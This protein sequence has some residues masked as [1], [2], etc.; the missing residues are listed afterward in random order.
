MKKNFTKLLKWL[1]ALLIFMISFY[2]SSQ[3]TI[4]QIPSFPF[5]DKIVHFICFGGLAF[6][7]SFGCNLAGKSKKEIILPTIIVSLYGILDEI[8]QSF[9]PGRSSTVSDWIADTLG[10]LL[11]SYVFFLVLKILRNSKNRKLSQ[12]Q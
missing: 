7:V 9:T 4:P 3:P 12:E 2:L 8:H 10:G 5:A 11:G 1:P 6:W